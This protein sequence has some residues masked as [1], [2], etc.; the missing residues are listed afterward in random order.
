MRNSKPNG[1]PQYYVL[2]CPDTNKQFLVEHGKDCDKTIVELTM[3]NVE[4]IRRQFLHKETPTGKFRR[5]A[6]LMSFLADEFKSYQAKIQPLYPAN[7]PD[8]IDYREYDKAKTEFLE[9]LWDVISQHFEE[10]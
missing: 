5:Q 9:S 6:D 7:L 1:K 10:V 4:T 8:D 2:T 3:E